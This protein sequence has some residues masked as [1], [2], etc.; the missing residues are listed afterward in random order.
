MEAMS[1]V[2]AGAGKGGGIKQIKVFHLD[3]DEPDDAFHRAE[4]APMLAL[5][6][7]CSSRLITR[8]LRV[9]TSVSSA[10]VS[11]LEK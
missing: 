10:W 8:F 3:F 9:G 6:M 11:T 5:L 4:P 7:L 2:L 1:E